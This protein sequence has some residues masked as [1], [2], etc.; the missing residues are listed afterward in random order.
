MYLIK[1]L[2]TQAFMPLPVALGLCVAGLVLLW[3]TRKQKTGKGFITAGVILLILTSYSTLPDRLLS[4][5]E[6]ENAPF[7]SQS[8]PLNEIKWIVILGS[9]N[10]SQPGTARDTALTSS[11]LFRVVEG[12]RLHR[13]LPQAKLLFCGGPTNNETPEAETMAQAALALGV[14]E[15]DIAREATSLDTADQVERVKE[16]VKSDKFILVSSAFHLPRAMFL[17]K[18]SGLEPTPDAVDYRAGDHGPP[19]DA[20]F[21]QSTNIR[22]FEIAIHEY[23]GMLWYRL[24][25]KT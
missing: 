10:M 12:V 2:I 7:V 1:K 16:I 19:P 9:G 3:F 15:Q 4:A 18:R 24:R 25:R 13:S 20:V 23:L 21:P 8:Q 22:K 6:Q 17:F 14:P 5:L 11:S